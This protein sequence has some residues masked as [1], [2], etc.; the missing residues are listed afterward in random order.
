LEAVKIWE[1]TDV[2][3]CG[4]YIVQYTLTLAE[5]KKIE[6]ERERERQKKGGGANSFKTCFI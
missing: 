2:V 1:N 5:E 6:R 3:E 4:L